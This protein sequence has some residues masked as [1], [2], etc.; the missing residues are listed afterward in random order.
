MHRHLRPIVAL[1]V[2]VASLTACSNDPSPPAMADHTPNPSPVVSSALAQQLAAARVATAKYATDLDAA[3]RDG[4]GII[5]PMMPEMGF[6]YL[7]P[8][9]EGFDVTKPAILV[10]NKTGP[11]WQLSALEWVFPATPGTPPLEGATYGSFAAACHYRDGNFVPASAEKDCAP[12][13]STG[14]P[15]NFWHPDLTTLH[16]WLWMPNPAGLYNGT[17]PLVQ[18]YPVS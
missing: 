3:Q 13:S 17:N 14:S 15:F 7:N 5:T 4:Y 16:V 9:I 6:H 1:A 8:K 11:S 10:Y 2:I 18:A 12:T